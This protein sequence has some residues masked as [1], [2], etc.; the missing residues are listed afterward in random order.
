MTD[1]QS[2]P[3]ENSDREILSSRVFDAPREAVFQAWI[4]PDEL[5]RWWGPKGFTNT[6]HAFDPRPGG[7]WL[8]IMHGPDGTD[9]KNRSVFVEIDAP[10]R[11]VF[12]HVSGPRFRATVT[13]ADKD[14]KTELTWRMLFETAAEYDGV[15]GFAVDG[16]RQNLDKLAVCLADRKTP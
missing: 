4:D 1:K 8:F 10:N 11:I 3:E 13:F 14:G 5:R 7:E 16:N 15:K 2:A 12:D 9:Y 6:F